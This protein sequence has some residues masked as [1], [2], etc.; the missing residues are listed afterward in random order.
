L[1]SWPK[2]FQKHLGGESFWKNGVQLVDPR[3][4][5]WGQISKVIFFWEKF[6]GIFL[7]KFFPKGF[8]LFFE[9]KFQGI[10]LQKNFVKRF[11][12]KFTPWLV[13]H[14]LHFIG[15]FFIKPD[16]VLHV[17]HFIG[18]SFITKRV[19][20]LKRGSHRVPEPSPLS[21]SYPA[22]HGMKSEVKKWKVKSEKWKSDAFLVLY[23]FSIS[24]ILKGGLWVTTTLI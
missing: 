22:G 19:T 6:T 9:K 4:Y 7:Q 1:G 14:V 16:L 3:G 21:T 5:F 8:P 17:L 2:N 15:D 23:F 12:C 20:C 11:P 13:L 24:D 18:I 10:F